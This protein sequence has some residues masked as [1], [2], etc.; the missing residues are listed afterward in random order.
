MVELPLL[1]PEMRVQIQARTLDLSDF[2]LPKGPF[3]I[4]KGINKTGIFC[5]RVGGGSENIQICVT[6][7]MNSQ[8]KF[9][10]KMINWLISSNLNQLYE[11][12]H[13]Q[14]GIMLVGEPMSCKTK[15]Y[16]VLSDTLTHLS[17]QK[18][19]KHQVIKYFFNIFH[20]K[21]SASKHCLMNPSWQ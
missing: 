8:K 17:E 20:F 21:D 7:I 11:M 18:E 12:I 15:L 9:N 1:V 16:E 13:V 4:N 2:T 14:H 19:A 3:T 6:L 5:D 10:V